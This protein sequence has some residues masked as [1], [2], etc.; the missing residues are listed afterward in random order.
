MPGSQQLKPS[1]IT[2]S[3]G[4]CR[5]AFHDRPAAAGHL[6]R[7]PGRDAVMNLRIRQRRTLR[8]IERDLTGSDPQLASLF[9]MFAS[10]TPEE[11]IPDAETLNPGPG[12]MLA[13]LGRVVGSSR[14]HA[15]RRSWLWLFL[16]L[17]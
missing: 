3:V 15:R 12:R 7:R 11:K 16:P 17:H 2:L 14:P 8:G 9:T 10:L 6:T 13:W 1:E 5:I 4:T